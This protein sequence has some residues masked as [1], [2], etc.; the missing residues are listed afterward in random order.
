MLTSIKYVLKKIIENILFKYMIAFLVAMIITIVLGVNFYAFWVVIIT[1]CAGVFGVFVPIV[2]KIAEKMEYNISPFLKNLPLNIKRG[3]FIVCFGILIGI[4]VV[5]FVTQK[6][7]EIDDSLDINN[8]EEIF[9]ITAL[10]QIEYEW[11]YS[12]KIKEGRFR[13][14]KR[15]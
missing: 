4:I 14:C 11:I 15:L 5:V 13:I 12:L 8:E 1:F 10:N 3:V 6:R 9:E 7:E 2:E